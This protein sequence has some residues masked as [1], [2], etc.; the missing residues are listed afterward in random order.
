MLEDVRRGLLDHTMTLC[1]AIELIRREAESFL[2][3]IRLRWLQNER[4]GYPQRALDIAESSLHEPE[5]RK[6][7]GTYLAQLPSGEWV[8]VSDTNIGD[9]PAF[10][11]SDIGAIEE[12]LSQSEE[13]WYDLSLV[14]KGIS[15]KLRVRREQLVNIGESVRSRLVDLIDELKTETT[16]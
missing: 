12:F 3:D 5:Y 7:L 9:Y 14:V 4:T 8:D 2:T 13:E 10:L 1:D 6:L 16:S 15:F 11:G